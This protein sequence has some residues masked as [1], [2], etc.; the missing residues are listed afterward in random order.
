MIHLLLD[1]T[2]EQPAEIGEP[3]EVAKDIRIGRGAGGQGSDASFRPTTNR[4][5]EI[6]RGSERRLAWG[7]ASLA[8]E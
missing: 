7:G 4:P 1:I 5:R 2:R 3:V 6:E 8:V